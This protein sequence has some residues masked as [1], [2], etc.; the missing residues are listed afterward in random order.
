MLWNN[1]KDKLPEIGQEALVYRETS[2]YKIQDI[3][4]YHGENKWIDAFDSIWTTEDLDITYWLP[5]PKEPCEE[6]IIKNEKLCCANCVFGF[7][8]NNGMYI[9]NIANKATHAD[10]ACEDG[11]TKEDWENKYDIS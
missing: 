8:Q 3:C 7:K 9:C 10:D 1:V 4:I 2:L 5:L 6:T 11:A